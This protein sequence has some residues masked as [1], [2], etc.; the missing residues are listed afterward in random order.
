LPELEL[1][2]V[3]VLVLFLLLLFFFFVVDF[4]VSVLWGAAKATMP[5]SSER[6]SIRLIIFFILV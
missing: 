5:V 3:I 6:P 4:V 2:V 1:D